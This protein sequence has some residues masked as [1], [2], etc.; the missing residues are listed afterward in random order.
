MIKMKFKEFGRSNPWMSEHRK[1]TDEKTILLPE[2]SKQL[3]CPHFG[4]T[5]PSN[6]LTSCNFS[7]NTREAHIEECKVSSVEE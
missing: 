3:L 5:S 1:E 6:F 4:F 7:G 2:D